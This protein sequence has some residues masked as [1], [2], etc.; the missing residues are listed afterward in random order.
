MQ[1]L[2]QYLPGIKLTGVQETIELRR[3]IM[4]RLCYFYVQD[5]VQDHR[6]KTYIYPL[7]RGEPIQSELYHLPLAESWETAKERLVQSP[8]TKVRIDRQEISPHAYCSPQ[9]LNEKGAF[10][11]FRKQSQ[12]HRHGVYLVDCV[13]PEVESMDWTSGV[14]ATDPSEVLSDMDREAEG[15]STELEG[16]QSMEEMSSGTSV[17]QIPALLNRAFAVVE[18]D[19]MDRYYRIPF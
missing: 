9:E 6:G 16:V 5:M 17:S 4:E 1:K 14:E 10:I 7:L 15:S 12:G 2:S 8:G 3:L 18:K 19:L 13:I 11:R